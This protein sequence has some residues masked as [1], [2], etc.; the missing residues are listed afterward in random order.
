MEAKVKGNL[1][2]VIMRNV[3][4][5]N[6]THTVYQPSVTFSVLLS[7]SSSLEPARVS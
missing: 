4:I 7:V 3:I 1:F 6:N 5:I 2:S